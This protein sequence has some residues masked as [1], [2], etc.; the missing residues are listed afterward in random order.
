MPETCF[1]L[2]IN[3]VELLGRSTGRCLISGLA[4]CSVFFVILNLSKVNL[5]M[6]RMVL[7]DMI[8]P[9]QL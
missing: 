6:V 3:A 5:A 7:Q 1:V 9:T 8:F 2:K 4:L